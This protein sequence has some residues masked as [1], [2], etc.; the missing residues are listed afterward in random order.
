ME[1]IFLSL[2][3]IMALGILIWVMYNLIGEISAVSFVPSN[4]DEIETILKKINPGK[5]KLFLDLGSGDGR[6]V[7][8]AVI[9]HEV[10][11]VGYEI[12]PLLVWYSKWR[13]R[14][15]KNLDFK[16]QSMWEADLSP[17]DYIYC[18]LSPR[19]MKKLAK[20]IQEEC[21]KGTVMVSKA[22]E[23]KSWDMH[24]SEKFQIN[25]RNF[26]VYKM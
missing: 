13:W 26:F 22:F 23:I 18:Y 11:G 4:Q 7:R 24:L 8:T 21:K 16:R 14:K 1:L 6:V 3:L 17:A 9:K 5:N 15:V 20:K 12:H 19:A 10:R 25:G 2:S